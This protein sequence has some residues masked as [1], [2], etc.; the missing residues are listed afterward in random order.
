M[1]KK[2]TQETFGAQLKL[3]RKKTGLNP[4]DFAQR[5]GLVS[6]DVIQLFEAGGLL[7]SAETLAKICLEYKA[8]INELLTGKV[9]PSISIEV[10]ALRKIKHDFRLISSD[11]RMQI[12]DLQTL[13]KTIKKVVDILDAGM[14]KHRQ[15][16]GRKRR[17]KKS[18]G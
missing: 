8:D 12:R 5:I 11:V 10:E 9:A 3:L 7:P 13:N 4:D 17:D 16:A 1:A 2:S 14:K 15:S 6:S 18:D